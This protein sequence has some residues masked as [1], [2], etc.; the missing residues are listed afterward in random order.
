MTTV[1]MKIRELPKLFFQL[2]ETRFPLLLPLLISGIALAQQR[3]GE[4]LDGALAG[5]GCASFMILII[6]LAV[7]ISIALLVWV[8]KDAKNRG[9]D[10][11]VLWMI[12][13][14]FT[15]LIGLIVYLL[16]RPKGDLFLCPHCK[17]KRLQVLAKCPHCGNA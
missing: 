1:G 9:M 10:N 3:P 11:A 16:V 6:I 2:F 7:A 4:N 8:A 13:V 12:I 5:C 17:N 14:F 15:G